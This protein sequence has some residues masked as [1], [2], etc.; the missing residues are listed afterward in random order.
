MSIGT[1]KLKAEQISLHTNLKQGWISF[2]SVLQF[3]NLP[4]S[5]CIF[6]SYHDEVDVIKM[7]V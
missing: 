2:Y 4:G 1:L 6:M 7:L 5:N 3:I